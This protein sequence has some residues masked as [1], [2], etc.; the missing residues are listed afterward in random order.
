M[1]SIGDR[2]HL[3]CNVGCDCRVSTVHCAC[4]KVYVCVTCSNHLLACFD[5]KYLQIKPLLDQTIS[6]M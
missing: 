6:I 5:N 3:L 4:D 2:E 1:F